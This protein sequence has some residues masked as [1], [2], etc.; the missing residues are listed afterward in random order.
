MPQLLR[1]GDSVFAVSSEGP[2][3]L[4]PFYDKQGL[5]KTRMSTFNVLHVRVKNAL[6]IMLGKS[7]TIYVHSRSFIHF[8]PFLITQIFLQNGSNSYPLT[9]YFLN[10]LKDSFAQLTLVIPQSSTMTCRRCIVLSH[11]IH[12]S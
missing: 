10:S 2:P 11:F 12:R 1:H 8:L 3:Q 7:H 6:R 5:L 4:S 9:I